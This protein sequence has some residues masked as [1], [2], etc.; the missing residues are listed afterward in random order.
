MAAA[1]L[2]LAAPAFAQDAT[3]SLPGAADPTAALDAFDLPSAA[4]VLI[5]GR[6]VHEVIP[7]G[8]ADL[9]SV[10]PVTDRTALEAASLTKSVFAYIVMILV[11][12]GLIDLDPP[13]RLLGAS[14]DDLRPRPG[15]SCRTLGQQR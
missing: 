3:R 13:P 7:A 9:P 6:A 5:Q 2:A 15:V 10:R 12:D 4:I 11:D 1:T 14:P 8:T